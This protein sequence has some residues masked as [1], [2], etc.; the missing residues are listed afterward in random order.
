[1]TVY[2]TSLIQ[3]IVSQKRIHARPTTTMTMHK[4]PSTRGAEE[5]L[6]VRVV[7]G[8]SKGNSRTTTPLDLR[9]D[10]TPVANEHSTINNAQKIGVINKHLPPKG[11]SIV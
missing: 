1:M 11:G 4:P 3:E 10:P 7:V 2:S 6:K 9:D 8:G 5:P